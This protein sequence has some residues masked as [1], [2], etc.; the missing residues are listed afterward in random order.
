MGYVGTSER[1]RKKAEA[2][3]A[4]GRRVARADIKF[5]ENEVSGGLLYRVGL[6]G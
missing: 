6:I 2:K 4:M 1:D 3:E 5:E